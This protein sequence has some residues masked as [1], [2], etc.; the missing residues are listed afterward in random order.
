MSDTQWSPT[1][2]HQRRS[3]EVEPRRTPAELAQNQLRQPRR[4]LAYGVLLG[5]ATS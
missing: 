5:I 3:S 1:G 2:H 4:L